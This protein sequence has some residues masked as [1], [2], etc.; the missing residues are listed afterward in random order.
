LA[1]GATIG[2]MPTT[3]GSPIAPTIHVVHPIVTSVGTADQYVEKE[4]VDDHQQRTSLASTSHNELGG[5]LDIDAFSERLHGIE[6]T[7][8]GLGHWHTSKPVRLHGVVHKVRPSVSNEGVFTATTATGVT[9]EVN[10]LVGDLMQHSAKGLGTT[11]HLG[12]DEL[13]IGWRVVE[14]TWSTTTVNVQ[15]RMF[16][17]GQ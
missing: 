1:I 14:V 8:R 9:S 2:A 17:V 11:A 10:G 5:H 7:D 16:C 4:G 3:R 6:G 15:E 12:D 13:D